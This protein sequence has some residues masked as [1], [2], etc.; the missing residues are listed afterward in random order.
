ML[1]NL[2]AKHKML[3]L[4]W[5]FGILPHVTIPHHLNQPLDIV[6]P[7]NFCNIHLSWQLKNYEVT[8]SVIINIKTGLHYNMINI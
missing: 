1:K 2:R 8:G 5:S 4:I 6:N 7:T 3:K